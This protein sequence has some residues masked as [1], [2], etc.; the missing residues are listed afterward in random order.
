[1]HLC[2]SFLVEI[3]SLINLV[4]DIFHLLTGGNE[5]DALPYVHR[6]L[7]QKCAVSVV[8]DVSG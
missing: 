6:G 8:Q 3:L 1:M 7:A 5:R 4:S 2:V